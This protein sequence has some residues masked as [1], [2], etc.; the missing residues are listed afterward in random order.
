MSDFRE[1]KRSRK[2]KVVAGV[3]GGIGEYFRIDPVIVRLIMVFTFG[4]SFWLYIVMWLV[5][6]EEPIIYKE[7]EKEVW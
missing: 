6:P 3:C 5:V 4:I 7:K 1:L 2:N